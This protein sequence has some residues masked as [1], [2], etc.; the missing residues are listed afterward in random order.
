MDKDFRAL[1]NR[2]NCKLSKAI[3]RLGDVMFNTI[4]HN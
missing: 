1:E 4:Y 2:L 3:E